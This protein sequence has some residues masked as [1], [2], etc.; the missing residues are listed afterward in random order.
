MLTVG[1]GV[2]VTVI[3]VESLELPPGPLQDKLKVA[4]AVISLTISKPAVGLLPDQPPD[5]VQLSASVALQLSVVEPFWETLDGLAVR[6]TTGDSGAATATKTESLTLPIGPLQTRV[7]LVLEV[8][9]LILSEPDDSPTPDQ[10]PEAVQLVALLEVQLK[11]VEPPNGRLD[12]LADR[13]A[14]GG[15]GEATITLTESFASPPIPLQ[16]KLKVLFEVR[17]LI[18]CDPDNAFSPT[19][20][21]EAVQAVALLLLQL[22]VVDPL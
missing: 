1:T 13:F 11:V 19:Q 2:A 9:L 22:S 12:G 8:R 10:P 14:V 16:D 15:S 7:K 3:T 20:S 4:V 6:F 17:A 21:P 18:V 5:A